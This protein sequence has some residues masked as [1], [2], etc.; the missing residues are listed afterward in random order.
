VSTY[1]KLPVV[2]EAI[3]WTGRNE[4]ELRD[5]TGGKFETIPR[6]DRGDPE[7]TAEVYDRLHST[8]V[9]VKTG[10]SVLRGVKGEFYPIDQEVLAETY[11]LVADTPA[12]D[13]P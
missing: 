9:G 7:I 4:Q 12:G 5:W 13:V 8:W 3:Q 11:E 6:L 2:V 1:R 10:Q